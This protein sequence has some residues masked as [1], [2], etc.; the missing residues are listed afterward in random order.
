MASSLIVNAEMFRQVLREN[1]PL[2]WA[3]GSMTI[4]SLF[5]YNYIH[6]IAI[7]WA[8]LAGIGSFHV[9]FKQYS[10]LPNLLIMYERKKKQSTKKKSLAEMKFRRDCPVC[11][12]TNCTRH[13][14]ELT[15]T[16]IQPWTDL[17]IPE[18][19]D[20][21]LAELLELVLKEYVYSWYGDL[22][23]NEQ[24][25]NE[26]RTAFRFM[27]AVILRRIR[28]VDLPTV[29][30]D[31]LIKAALAHLDVHLRAQR[32][33][34]WGE[35][36]EEL[37]IKAYGKNR[38]VVMWNREAELEYLRHLC[39]LLFPIILSPQAHD[40]QSTR[41][42]VREVLSASVI[43]NAMD[44][45][46]NPD[47]VNLLLLIFFDEEPMVSSTAPPTPLVNILEEFDMKHPVKEATS[48]LH[49]EMSNLIENSSLLYNFQKFMK[50]EGALNI[51]QFCLT[52][53][54]FNR[55]SLDPDMT[56]AQKKSL[57][58]EAQSLYKSYFS[59]G[60][61]DRIEFEH[62]IEE[63]VR[64]I[65]NGPYQE[66]IR[67]RT[68]SALFRA[69]EN[70]YKLLENVF[71]PLFH[72]SDEYYTMLCGPR[73]QIFMRAGKR[74]VQKRATEPLAAMKNLGS[75][76]KGVFKG[77]AGEGGDPSFLSLDLFD[78]DANQHTANAEFDS[79]EDYQRELASP[80]HDLGPW[81]VSIPRVEK[82]LEDR[83]EIFVYIIEV[84]R[85]DVELGGNTGE[86]AS[87]TVARRYTEF[88]V[89][90]N[91]LKEFH[92]GFED[93][94][95]P[96]KRPFST[97]S[98]EFYER[99]RLAL[100]KY[101]QTLLTK[102]ILRSSQLLYSFLNYSST[103]DEFSNKFLEDVNLSKLMRTVSVKV[104]KERGQHLEPFLQTLVNAVEAPMPKPS[105]AENE[106]MN[107]M[108]MVEDKA[109]NA[110]FNN[111]LGQEIDRTSLHETGPNPEADYL[112]L[113]GVFDYILYAARVLFEVTPWVHHGLIMIR[114]LFKNSLETFVDS[115]LAGKLD[116]V[117]EEEKLEMIIHLLRD[118]LFF[119]TDPPRTE[120][121]KEARKKEAFQEMT[122]FFPSVIPQILGEDKFYSGCKVVFDGLQYPKLNKQLSYVLLD[123]ILQEVFPE[124]A[125]DWE[126]LEDGQKED[127]T[128][129]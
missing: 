38:H 43:M 60:A 107:P 129:T 35:N 89:L 40:S 68:S 92:G 22:S 39:E 31:K 23:K 74:V 122:K 41:T 91:K 103:S 109:S 54:D 64:D 32:K 9:I 75:K 82:R 19:V 25:V 86:K 57:H 104:I 1:A 113:N 79:T 81:R 44:V 118:A 7:G 123:I 55:R 5:F 59:P 77:N 61:V 76:I 102:P 94:T 99:K 33:A 72:Q 58:K 83:K 98:F 114:K 29:I 20:K 119:D 117:Q 48:V 105:K 112:P 87:W 17:R 56:E 128:K 15:L 14:G 84:Q 69:Y 111:N 97:R 28:E 85:V 126:K 52:V 100:E 6:I 67:L 62:D 127:E 21:A 34:K 50:R 18:R 30:T 80:I 108:Q 73:Q 12:D 124:I 121:Q 27:V 93:A 88:Y 10:T 53:E 78:S 26:L 120:D 24:F 96:Q 45:I 71:C 47:V 116:Q 66:V 70:A 115:Y 16:S 95:L 106:E 90:E 36:V 110:L 8:F 3:L 125:H 65:A 51:L 13:R 11:G 49:M 4:L 37:T 63:E 101:I 2:K 42:F 46:A